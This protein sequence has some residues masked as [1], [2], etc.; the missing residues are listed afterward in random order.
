MLALTNKLPLSFAG[1]CDSNSLKNRKNREY[2]QKVF[3]D[4]GIQLIL[5]T[6]LRQ[7]AVFRKTDR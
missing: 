4:S 3:A 5:Q 2:F 6:Q 1:G 7:Y